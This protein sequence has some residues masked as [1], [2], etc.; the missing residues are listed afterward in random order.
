MEEMVE[1]P[2]E[3]YLS[4]LEQIEIDLATIIIEIKKVMKDASE[5]FDGEE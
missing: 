2:L 4:R 5:A 3:S 1:I